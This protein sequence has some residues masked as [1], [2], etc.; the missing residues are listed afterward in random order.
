MTTTSE[1][2]PTPEPDPDHE[3]VAEA[4]PE[5]APE[6]GELLAIEIAGLDEEI[7]EIEMLIQQAQAEAERHEQRRTQTTSRLEA[8]AHRGLPL[9]PEY[10]EI[11]NQVILLTR[12]AA[13]MT[14][15][16]EVLE[17]KR[18]TL[19]RFRDRLLRLQAELPPSVLGATARRAIETAQAKAIADAN[20]KA[21]TPAVSRAMLAVQEDLRREIARAMHDGPAQSL[22]NIILQAQIVERLAERDP[23]RVSEEVR[24]LV[25]MVQR[26]LEATK[27]FIFDVRPM[28]LDDLGLVP[29]IRRAVSDRGRRAHVLIELE[30][31]GVDR[32]LPVDIESGAFRIVDEALA[33]FIEAH[34]EWIVMRF[35]WEEDR[36]RIAITARVTESSAARIPPRALRPTDEDATPLPPTLAAIIQ[37]DEWARA[38]AAAP[39][40]PSLPVSAWRTI[41]HRAETIGVA[42][43]LS[44]DG[45]ELRLIVPY[46]TAP[47]GQG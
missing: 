6:I 24:E 14:A 11:A 3:R 45:T 25:A 15:Q 43:E 34:P 41:E 9:D 23:S 27:S 29:T 35:E 19:T 1:T 30:A 4:P 21:L 44:S 8:T 47:A 40:L 37:E 16:V 2:T 38:L 39:V 33:G 26:T 46:E 18:K 42:V 5:R 20:P 12:R 32:R 36:L 31:F 17:G 22:T 7:G 28:V 10:V 13:V